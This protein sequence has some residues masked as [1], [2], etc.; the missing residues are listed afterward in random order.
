MGGTPGMFHAYAVP[1]PCRTRAE[2]MGGSSCGPGAHLVHLW[3]PHS[4]FSDHHPGDLGTHS[5]AALVRIWGWAGEGEP[6]GAEEATCFL[7]G[8]FSVFASISECLLFISRCSV[9]FVRSGFLPLLLFSGSC[10]GVCVPVLCIHVMDSGERTIFIVCW[11]CHPSDWCPLSLFPLSVSL[12]LSSRPLSLSPSLSLP[13]K[14]RM[15]CLKGL[16]PEA[17]LNPPPQFSSPWLHMSVWLFQ[18]CSF[19]LPTPPPHLFCL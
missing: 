18:S 19:H 5:G 3:P 8:S 15:D 9:S 7:F 14:K 10:P 6:R 16:H 13:P 11:P 1:S 17:S 12:S 4:A 2:E